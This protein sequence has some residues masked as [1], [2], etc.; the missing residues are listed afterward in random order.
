MYNNEYRSLRDGILKALLARDCD[1]LRNITVAL[2]CFG[3]SVFCV[4]LTYYR[5]T[6]QDS[7]EQRLYFTLALLPVLGFSNNLDEAF[8]VQLCH[9]IEQCI[10]AGEPR[11]LAKNLVNGNLPLLQE[12][13]RLSGNETIVQLVVHAVLLANFLPRDCLGD[14]FTLLINNPMQLQVLFSFL[15]CHRAWFNC[16]SVQ[17][18]Y[19]PAM[20]E[21]LVMEGYNA[22]RAVKASVTLNGRPCGMF[23]S[24]T[25][26]FLFSQLAK[27]DIRTWLAIVVIQLV[28]LGELVS[29]VVWWSAARAS[30]ILWMETWELSSTLGFHIVV[31]SE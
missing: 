6:F 18:S 9:V 21:D 5:G 12:I 11:E 30:T 27:T 24:S 16:N 10:P 20:P 19:F 23:E 1:M 22:A 13:R 8:L 2:V 3:S 15:L 26:S 28:E 4:W 14:C 25:F 29:T 31:Q 17:N 7:S